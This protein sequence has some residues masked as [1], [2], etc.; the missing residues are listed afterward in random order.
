MAEADISYTPAKTVRDFIRDHTPGEL[1]YNFIVGP[2]GS[3]KTTGDIMK[4]A[5]MAG[6]Q[7]KSPVDGIRRTRVVVVRST[8]PQL[9]DTTIPSFF[10]WFKPGV[11]G[12]WKATQKNFTLRF[13][14]VECEVLFRPL[15]T[16][17]DVSRVL[18]LEVTHAVLDEF[19]DI[20][21]EIIEALSGRCGR[22][23]SRKDGGATHFGMWGASNPGNE[24]SWW[25]DFL[26]LNKPENVNYYLQPGGLSPDAENLENLPKG[27]YANL[28]KG[29]TEA[30][31]RQFVGVQWGFDNRGK[32]VWPT[33]N[34][35]IHVSETPLMANPHLPLVLGLDPGLQ[36]A[37]IFGQYDLHGRLIILGELVTSGMGAERVIS[38][39]LRPLLAAKYRGFK[40][41][42]ASDP[43]AANRA[44]TDEKSVVDVYRRHF[45]VKY[46]T[47]NTLEPRI[48]AVDAFLCKLTDTGPG[49]IIDPS[50]KILIRALNGGYKYKIDTKGRE[51][52]T[53]DKDEFSHPADA[54]GY[55]AKYFLAASNRE[56]RR[57]VSSF[58]PPTFTNPY[59]HR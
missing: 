3:G 42:I 10:T 52:P 45:D 50:C 14:D 12:D 2:Y 8:A 20:P 47:D 31:V 33:F 1:F 49:L 27:Y 38:E 32:P 13:A 53:P 25:Y 22:Y 51:S 4:I 26:I 34:Q 46:D 11:A 29:K 48:S 44:Q 41:I 21:K 58:K 18:S 23:P 6:L 43:A 16:P 55:L 39:R 30:W 56:L 5:Y 40:P 36:S 15:D 17:D 35:K 24:T 57:K 7:D 59:C 28:I 9:M 37:L 19:V 54:L